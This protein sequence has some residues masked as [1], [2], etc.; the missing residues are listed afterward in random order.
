MVLW[1][2]VSRSVDCFTGNERHDGR[3]RRAHSTCTTLSSLPSTGLGVVFRRRCRGR[4]R[5]LGSAR[6]SPR[7]RSEMTH[8]ARG[9][10]P[11]YFR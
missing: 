10:D 3:V 5:A 6:N 11:F 7:Q 1:Y 4:A 9:A 8:R 2:G